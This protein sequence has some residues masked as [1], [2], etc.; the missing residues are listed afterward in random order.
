MAILDIR[1]LVAGMLK[2][3]LFIMIGNM[4]KKDHFDS[5]IVSSSILYF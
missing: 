5:A 2:F 4:I 3:S 1:Q